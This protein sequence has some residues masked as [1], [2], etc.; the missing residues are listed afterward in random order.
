MFPDLTQ[1]CPKLRSII[2][3]Q[4]Y[5]SIG[6][7]FT[8]GSYLRYLTRI[9]VF[10]SK[11]IIHPFSAPSYGR[12]VPVPT[13]YLF[14]HLPPCFEFLHLIDFGI[15]VYLT[16]ILPLINNGKSLH[17]KFWVGPHR[18]PNLLPYIHSFLN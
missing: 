15:G 4:H 17:H 1:T 7:T 16:K 13:G 5:G 14:L 2:I 18:R 9:I 3:I 6:L 12:R 11:G 8:I 10:F